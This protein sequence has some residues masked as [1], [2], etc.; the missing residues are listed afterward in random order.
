M[1]LWQ[2]HYAVR[3][4]VLRFPGNEIFS[5]LVTHERGACDSYLVSD[6]AVL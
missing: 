4:T 6:D 2:L 1:Q 3:G 5:R